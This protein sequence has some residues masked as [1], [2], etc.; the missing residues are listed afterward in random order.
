MPST[1]RAHEAAHY[2]GRT[3]H[4][5]NPLTV[6]RHHAENAAVCPAR[7]REGVLAEAKAGV[8]RVRK[9]ESTRHMLP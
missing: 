9:L 3:L 5:A 6:E 8:P 2:P 1:C 4:A 7:L